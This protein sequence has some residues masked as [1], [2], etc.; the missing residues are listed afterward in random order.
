MIRSFDEDGVRLDKA[1]VERGLVPSRARAQSLIRSKGGKGD[2]KNVTDK[3]FI[4]DEE[5]EVVLVTQDLRWVSRAGLKLEHAL[6]FWHIDVAGKVALD[7]GASTGGFTDVLLR[8][9]ERRVGKESR[10]R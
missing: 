3:D 6:T 4:V 5:T 1:L 8:S 9:E 7:V 10:S 2:G